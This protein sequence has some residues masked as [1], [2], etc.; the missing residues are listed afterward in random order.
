MLHQFE[1]GVAKKMTV[2]KNI[3]THSTLRA[4][5][6]R[7]PILL[8]MIKRILD[9]VISFIL[10]LLFTPVFLVILYRI[11]KNEG[12]PIFYREARIGKNNEPFIMWTFRTKSIPTQVIRSLPP[13]PVPNAWENGVPNEFTIKKIGYTP[14]TSTGNW[15]LK[16]NL[17]KLPLLFHVFK[18]DMSLVGPQAE[19][20]KVAKYYN[21]NQKQRL[22]VKP[23]VTGYAQVNNLTNKNHQQ[24]IAYDLYYIRNYSLR[25]DMKI[26]MQAIKHFFKKTVSIKN[27]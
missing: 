23:G 2:Q 4:A 10:I 7:K 12:K 9:I 14:I 17:H 6:Y 15:L 20:K 13:Y 24:K 21:A 3:N 26:I 8:L 18:G 25:F 22:Q 5:M 1:S 16:Y 11:N 19:V 27:E